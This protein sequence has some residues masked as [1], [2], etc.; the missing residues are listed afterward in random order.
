LQ[1][2]RPGGLGQRRVAVGRDI[3]RDAEGV[4]GDAVEKVAFDRFAGA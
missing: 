3:M 2:Q 1:Q 4:A